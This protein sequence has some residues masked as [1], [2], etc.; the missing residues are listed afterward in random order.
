MVGLDEEIVALKRSKYY[1]FGKSDKK[2]KMMDKDLSKNLNYIFYD[3][4]RE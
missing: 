2:E 3:E 1:L 4:D